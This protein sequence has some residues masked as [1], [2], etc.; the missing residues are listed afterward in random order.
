MNN[1]QKIYLLAFISFLVGTSQFIIVGVLDQI[2]DSLGIS[3]ASAG[4][5][6]S[7]YAL[8]SAI[9][10]PLVI[11]ATA[12]KDHRAQL[13]LALVVFIIGIFAMPLFQHYYL[14][15]LSRIIV[16]IGAG[17]FVVTAYAMSAQLAQRGKQ[18][19]AMSNIAMGFSLSLVLGVPLGRVITAIAHW[20]A[21]FWII[22][23]LSFI[24]FV[25][26]V[27]VIPKTVAEPPIGL[28]EQLSFLKEPKIMSALSITFLFFISFSLINTYITPFLFSIRFLS[29][30]EI[31]TILFSLGIAS[32][33][34]SK[35]AGFLADRMGIT[36]TLFGSMIVHLV[37]LLLLFW[38]THSIFLTST[39]LF[40]WVVASW[41]FGPTQS[42]NLASIAPKAAGIL[43]SLNS[44][45]VQLG[46]A[47]G[48]GLGGITIS[49]LPLIALSGVGILCIIGA[50]GLFLF[51]CKPSANASHTVHM[52]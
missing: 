16:G 21:I 9:G 35:L 36:R 12:K 10:T 20:Q 39:V 33:V 13:L 25:M 41:T 47:V 15:V 38:V 29:E 43:L 45:F 19:S 11:M 14:I 7:V 3:L 8:A 50:L 6:V 48:A 42:F 22:G 17:V 44:S 4:Q 37:M 1:V 23:I 32:F 52:L 5:L 30:H 49:H 27:K 26:V 28:Q 40:I 24:S 2:A 18:G 31:S 51:T 34:G 46:F